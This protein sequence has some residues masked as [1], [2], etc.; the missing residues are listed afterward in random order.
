M[1]F[2][3]FKNLGKQKKKLV[4]IVLKWTRKSRSS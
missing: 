3:T 2:K 4:K 1:F